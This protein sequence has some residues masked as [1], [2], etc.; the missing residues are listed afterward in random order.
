MSVDSN[1]TK[2]VDNTT[3]KTSSTYVTFLSF[4]IGV[5]KAIKGTEEMRN[6]IIALFKILRQAD[7]TVA[8]SHYKLDAIIDPDTA[9]FSTTSSLVIS[10]PSDVPTSI[11]RM[12]KFFHGARPN[13]KGGS[14]WTQ[15]CLCIILK[16]LLQTPART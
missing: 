16:I 12:G 7:D 5:E 10:D 14:I 9:L 4:Q 8:F 15:I 2:V 1:A 11:T 6:K 3:N 13:N